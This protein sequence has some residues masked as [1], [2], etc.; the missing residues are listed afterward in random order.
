LS[1]GG[2]GIFFLFSG[3]ERVLL[4]CSMTPHDPSFT[5]DADPAPLVHALSQ[6]EV[7]ISADRLADRI[8]ELGAEI[9]R[10]Y[11]GRPLRLIGVLKGAWM[12]LADLIRAIELEEVTVD[13]L[14]VATYGDAKQTSGEVRFTKDLDQSV[15]G[16]EV[17]L[18]ED[19]LDT[20]LTFDFILSVL[21]NRQPKSLR[22]VTLLDKASCRLR[23]V[24]AD[25]VGFTIPDQFVVGFGLDFAQN[26][27][28]LPYI[29]VL[30]GS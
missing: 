4:F 1:I 6:P 22:A 11:R 18:V 12:F 8:R 19:I 10:D 13:F 7:L 21:R 16:V 9:S 26:Y 30:K 29:G 24:H 17:L 20:G 28:Q 15:E 14:G 5:L 25:Y 27:R 3:L 23:P 2:R